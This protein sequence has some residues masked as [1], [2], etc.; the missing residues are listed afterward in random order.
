[1]RKLVIAVLCLLFGSS[2]FAQA[3]GDFPGYH[4][5]V[6]FYSAS[7][8]SLKTQLWSAV[9][10]GN[11]VEF[12]LEPRSGAQSFCINGPFLN[13]NQ[14]RGFVIKASNG[15]DKDEHWIFMP[16][17]AKSSENEWCFAARHSY[18][19]D[20]WLVRSGGGIALQYPVNFEIE[21]KWSYVT[22]LRLGS[23][24]FKQRGKSCEE[25]FCSDVLR[26]Q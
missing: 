3:S 6:K 2:V 12:D 4:T 15:D 10:R 11:Q 23:Q 20:V 26:A 5:Q 8:P 13:T 1:M 17:S 16:N 21:Q 7:T 19:F 24:G 18:R 22:D 25:K 9:Y 14:A